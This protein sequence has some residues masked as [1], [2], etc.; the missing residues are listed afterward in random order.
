VLDATLFEHSGF[1]HSGA[2]F[3]H[4]GVTSTVV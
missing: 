3:E 4:G 1:E 2:I